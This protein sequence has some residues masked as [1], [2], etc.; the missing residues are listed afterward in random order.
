MDAGVL[1]DRIGPLP[2]WGWMAGGGAIL[3]VIFIAKGGSG[4]GTTTPQTTAYTGGG[5]L[6]AA[7]VAAAVAQQ[8]AS[9]QSYL[10][11]ML[12]AA[13]DATQAQID[14]LTASD[15]AAAAAT[16]AANTADKTALQQAI[17]ALK[18]QIASLIA[19][20]K[21]IVSPV[22]PVGATSDGKI[23][24]KG[25]FLEGLYWWQVRDPFYGYVADKVRSWRDIPE[26][27]GLAQ[28]AKGSL[29]RGTESSFGFLWPTNYDPTKDTA[30]LS[31]L[32]QGGETSWSR[33]W[34]RF[35]DFMAANPNADPA[36]AF[37][38]EI[39][40]TAGDA[41]SQGKLGGVGFDLTGIK[42]Y[43]DAA[44]LRADEQ[45]LAQGFHIGAP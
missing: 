12:K 4:G 42:V 27:F 41:Q 18:A 20:A 9:D 11:D 31:G 29:T 38:L 8:S 24:G 2:A 3:A 40:R 34:R 30:I 19:A 35:R 45:L 14:A 36:E 7:D 15:A 23:H 39:G 1:T 6:S 25:S 28:A 32:A 22:V 13:S 33:T 5:G 43:N 17:D 26:A 37:K 16:A 21:P 44:T 10:T